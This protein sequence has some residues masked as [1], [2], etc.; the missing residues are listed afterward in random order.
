MNIGIAHQLAD[1]MHG[2]MLITAQVENEPVNEVW[3]GWGSVFFVLGMMFII[4]LV[5]SLV[6]WQVFRTKQSTIES[7]AAIAHEEAYRRL[8][9]EVTSIQNRTAAELHQLT[10]GMADLRVR[11][12]TIERMLRE[13]E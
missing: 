13:V 8:A 5:A 7:R 6:I 11:V 2:L 10:E 12:T 1:S 4:A 3:N 9:E